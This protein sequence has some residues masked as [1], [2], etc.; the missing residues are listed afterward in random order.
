MEPR[1]G[2]CGKL[3]RVEKRDIGI[4]GK[5]RTKQYIGVLRYGFILSSINFDSRFGDKNPAMQRWSH[6]PGVDQR[7]QDL[8][9]FPG[10]LS[11]Q[12]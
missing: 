8:F 10:A 9:Q 6:S 11:R 2:S 4:L 12:L 1:A 3:D 7:S 5:I